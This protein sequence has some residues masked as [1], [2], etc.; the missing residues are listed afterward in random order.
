MKLVANVLQ[1]EEHGTVYSI[2]PDDTVYN[3][4][5][6]MA[7]FDIGSLVV[8]EDARV[9]GMITERHYARNVILR[10]RS[11]P[12]TPIREVME[13]RVVYVGPRRTVEECMAVMTEKKIRH[14]PVM[15]DGLSGSSPSGIWSGRSSRS[16]NSSSTS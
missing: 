10:G 3:A 7:E 5:R 15:E 12:T 11:S 9:V 8:L 6:I 13:G 16:R 14:L 2:H 4:I 1:Q